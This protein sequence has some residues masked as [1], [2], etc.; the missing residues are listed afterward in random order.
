MR[1]FVYR[2]YVQFFIQIKILGKHKNH[3][4]KSYYILKFQILFIS[5][6][7]LELELNS[8]LFTNL[9]AFFLSMTNE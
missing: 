8:A 6:K 2:N 3:L 4:P 5:Y 7:G 9:I 1:C